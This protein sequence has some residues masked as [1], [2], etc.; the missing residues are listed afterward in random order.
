MLNNPLKLKPHQ[1][2]ELANALCE[3]AGPGTPNFFLAPSSARSVDELAAE[4]A[5]LQKAMEDAAAQKAIDE[6]A[7][8]KAIA[9]AVATQTVR[10]D[11]AAA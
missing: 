11:A 1:R 8:E 4:A 7:A 3:A 5:P 6:A 10:D 2:L 9:D